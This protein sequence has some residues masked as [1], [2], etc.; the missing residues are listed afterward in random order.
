MPEF[1][2]AR[3]ILLLIFLAVSP[4]SALVSPGEFGVGLNYPGVGARYILSKRMGVEARGQV[5]KDIF[6]GG[7]RGYWYFKQ[8]PRIALFT[9]AEFDYIRF[10]GRLTKGSGFAFGPF[11]GGEFFVFK[12]VS[13]QLDMAPMVI[14]LKDQ[15]S[16][17]EHTG[18][19]V[20]LNIGL[21]LYFGGDQ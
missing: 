19:D 12:A 1:R 4:S 8:Y 3:R 5:G 2:L 10:K 20:I 6:I 18:F 11:G 15:A 17:K 13:L 14:A 9:G 21:N 7:G 16:N